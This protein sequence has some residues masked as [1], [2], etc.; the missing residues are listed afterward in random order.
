MISLQQS[1]KHQELDEKVQILISRLSQSPENFEEVKNTILNESEKIRESIDSHFHKNEKRLAE[2]ECRIQLLESLWF[3]EIFSREETIARAHRE[4][5]GWIYD[6]SGKRVRPWDNFNSWLEN[7]RRTYWI[8]GKAGSGKSTLMS[9]LCQDDRTREA[10]K[11]WSGT[12]DLFMPRF[13]FWGSGSKSQMSLE[14]LLRSLLWQILKAFPD[15]TLPVFDGGP[16]IHQN[17][18][19]SSRN[20]MIGVWTK[21]RLQRA[22]K[23][24]IRQLEASCCLC[25]FIDGLDEFDQ[26]DDEM[27]ELVYDVISTTTTGVKVCLSSRPY[28]RFEVAFGS[29]AK[30]RL[31][32][33][34][35][36]DI[37]RF[38]TDKFQQVPQ[39]QSMTRDYLDEMNQLKREIVEK[40]QGVF[41]W[42][43]LAV[44]EQIRGLKNEDG[45]EMLR[46][47]LSLLPSE[48]EGVYS[49]MLYQIDRLH[50]PEASHFLRMVLHRPRMSLLEHALV[51]YKGLEEMLLSA[52]E[53]PKRKIHSQCRAVENRITVTCVGLLEVHQPSHSRVKVKSSETDFE[54]LDPSPDD[55]T[56]ASDAD[57]GSVQNSN[58]TQ[59]VESPHSNSIERGPSPTSE[60]ET[61]DA[62]PFKFELYTSVHFAH[63]TAVE[64]LENSEPGKNFLRAN[65]SPNFDPQVSY[66]KALLGKLK[67]TGDLD[68]VDDIMIEAADVEEG[69]GLAQTS[70]CE[71][72]DRTVSSIDHE[73]PDYCPDSHWCTRFGKL[74]ELYHNENEPSRSTL[75]SRSNSCDSFYS[76]ASGSMDFRSSIAAP[77]EPPSFLAFA[78]SHGLSWYVQQML[79]REQKSIGQEVLDYLLF[80]SV[81]LIP[82]RYWNGDLWSKSINVTPELLSRGANPNA[83]FLGKT[84]WNHFLEHLIFLWSVGGPLG[85]SHFNHHGIT[86]SVI[87]FIEHAADVRSIWTFHFV[88]S[89]SMRYLLAPKFGFDI[90]MSALLLIQAAMQSSPGFPQIQETARGAVYYSRCTILEVVVEETDC[91]S[92]DP[93]NVW[94]SKQYELSEQES[95]ELMEILI[96][97]VSLSQSQ[98]HSDSDKQYDQVVDLSRRLDKNRSQVSLP[99]RKGGL[100]SEWSTYSSKLDPGTLGFKMRKK[101]T[102]KQKF[103]DAPTSQR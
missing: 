61:P 45:P 5:F 55:T 2:E 62:G 51:C 79:D 20:N 100:G 23:D 77:M 94:L 9:F 14:G 101:W 98:V 47:R 40:A 36:D 56:L 74:A 92:R 6:K 26:D 49:R 21:D 17:R 12:K 75:S 25:F 1:R 19:S 8:S 43:S 81:V 76:A 42:V 33:L 72:I 30:L 73:H 85:D 71:L 88:S 82:Y 37:D 87:A 99:S 91:D 27:I 80:C 7:G 28:K 63:R 29:S 83:E 70:L 4:T 58:G 53:V 44:K 69:T 35:Y 84:I 41:L 39:L 68:D 10:L 93:W 67:V 54:Q 3:A 24:V 78:A 86:R 18:R 97:T 57:R 31:Q 32:D 34:T 95:K 22:L 66:I 46:E 102:H 50:R 65:S 59:E 64:F 48:I 89:I 96:P 13:F 60:S 15:L 90:Q 11:L 52:S 38:V 103:Y 16:S